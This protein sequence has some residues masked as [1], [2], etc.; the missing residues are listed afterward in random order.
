MPIAKAV[1]VAPPPGTILPT[2]FP[3]SCALATVNQL[4]TCKAIRLSSQRQMKLPTSLTSASAA[5][6]H[7]SLLSDRH[8][9]KTA[10]RLGGRM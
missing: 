3:L 1:A 2:V 10:A 5:Q 7:V 8:E 6:Y 9:E 4:L